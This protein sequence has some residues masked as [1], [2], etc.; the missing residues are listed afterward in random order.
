[1]NQ[2]RIAFK[3]VSDDSKTLNKYVITQG[4]VIFLHTYDQNN[5]S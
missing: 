1:M 4:T 5:I 2:F 3:N